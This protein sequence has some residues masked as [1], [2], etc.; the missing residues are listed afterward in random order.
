MAY[1]RLGFKIG[2]RL[3][4]K[5][6]LFLL[7]NRLVNLRLITRSPVSPDPQLTSLVQRKRINFRIVFKS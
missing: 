5:I 2:T 6:T 3:F 7:F 4:T 1:T